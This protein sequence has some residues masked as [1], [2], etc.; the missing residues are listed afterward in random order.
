[1]VTCDWYECRDDNGI[2]YQVILKRF[3]FDEQNGRSIVGFVENEELVKREE[4]RGKYDC[5]V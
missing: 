5:K 3:D 1:M 2:V 4:Y